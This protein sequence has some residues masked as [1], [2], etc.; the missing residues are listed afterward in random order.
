M[1]SGF[2]GIMNEELALY[3]TDIFSYYV[4]VGW[5]CFLFI[6]LYIYSFVYLFIVCVCVMVASHKTLIPLS[7]QNIKDKNIYAVCKFE[8]KVLL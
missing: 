3:F 4:P 7:V 5:L 6:H 1:T 2:Y 8:M